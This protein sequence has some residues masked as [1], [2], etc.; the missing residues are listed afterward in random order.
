MKKNH[1]I[2]IVV[3]LGLIVAI[4]AILYIKEM[5]SPDYY[6]KFQRKGEYYFRK[7]EWDRAAAE[8]E[9]A[10]VY[11]SDKFEPHYSLGLTYLKLRNLEPAADELTRAISIS[12][13]NMNARYSLGTTYQRMGKP[14]EALKEYLIVAK[15][16]PN[17]FNVFNSVGVIQMEAGDYDKAILALKQAIE[18]KPDYYQARINLGGVYE[19]QG[20]T[21]L[22]RK[23]YQEVQE[24]ASKST[25]TIQ[26]AKVAEKRLANLSK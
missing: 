11:R 10:I 15:A 1:V 12:P 18:I 3:L 2:A 20:K 21:G 26:Y 22:A 4:P 16:I 23:E 8:F 19:A 17:S 24:M 25:A 13:E 14:A 9:K 5:S 7:G 6:L